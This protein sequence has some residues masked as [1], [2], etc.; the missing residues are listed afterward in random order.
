MKNKED[1]NYSA[2]G[3]GS[4]VVSWLVALLMIAATALLI[5]PLTPE[6]E[7]GLCFP[8]PS[9]W[10][11]PEYSIPANTLLIAAAVI[12]AFLLNKK[13]SF[14][15]SSDPIL[16]T[17]MTVILA[18]NPV[19]TSYF[20]SPVFMLLVNLIC[21]DILMR[22][23]HSPN[24]TTSLFAVATW[25]SFGSMVQYAFI[26][27]MLVYP[28]MAIIIK[29]FR[30]KE[31]IAYLM[32]LVAPYW[33][34]YGFGLVSVSDFRLPNPQM[35]PPVADGGLMLCIFVSLG[36]LALMGLFTML[37][38]A[39][40]IYSGNMRVRT[41]NRIISFLGF[42]CLVCMVVDF[43]NFGAYASTFCFVSSVQISNAFALR[44]IP[45]GGIWFW[46]V[47][48]I[49]IFCFLMMLLAV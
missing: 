5:P 31:C 10:L 48:S 21:L 2:A 3:P 37:N 45:H 6:A 46:S 44:R 29:A 25:L 20:G 12:G 19:N 33:V 42:V 4:V 30:I 34:A 18:S 8:F 23:Y 47:L 38:N 27:M 22:A 11:P 26:P 49:F 28:V 14:V 17:A 15:R 43:D 13:F 9:G 7:F 36:T 41:L 32:G 1:G 40:L 39:M 35:A 16:P 24:A